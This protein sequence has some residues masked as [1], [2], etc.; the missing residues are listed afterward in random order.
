MSDPGLPGVIIPVHNASE[1]LNRCL[2]SVHRTVPD[3]TVVLVIDDASTEQS[4]GEIIRYWMARSGPVWQAR[5]HSINRGFV[6]TVNAGM[7]LLDGNV[8]LLNSDTVVTTGWLEGLSTCLNANPLTATATPWTNNGEI[9]SFPVFCV[10]NPL[11]PDPD[12]IAAILAQTDAPIYPEL[13]TAVGFCMAISRSAIDLLGLFDEERFG[14]GYGE[15]ND[16][17]VRA[18]N[19]G[20]KNVL[21]DNVYVA[22]AGGRSFG[23][24]GLTPDDDAMQRLLDKHPQ[25]LKEVMAFIDRDPLRE[26]RQVL[27]EKAQ[28]AAIDLS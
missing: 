21:C 14:L 18:R 12:A 22:H 28:A 6:A 1:D 16:F 23:P 10:N 8:I 7:K 20:M 3:G 4:V 26:I 11:P 9:V 5:T 24:L 15:E 13:P 27:V 19:A 25:Y 2:E 17:S